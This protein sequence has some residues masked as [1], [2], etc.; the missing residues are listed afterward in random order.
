MNLPKNLKTLI[1]PLNK[2][3]HLDLIPDNLEYLYCSHNQI[4][5]LNKLPET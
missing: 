4:K 2:I 5:K 1:C 3:E